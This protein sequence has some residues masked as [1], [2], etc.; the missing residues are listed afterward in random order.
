MKPAPETKAKEDDE[1]A[2]ASDGKEGSAEVVDNHTIRV[3]LSAK[4]PGTALF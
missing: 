1:A 2:E 4:F 3:V